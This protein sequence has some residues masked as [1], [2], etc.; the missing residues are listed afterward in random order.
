MSAYTEALRIQQAKAD[1]ADAI[2]GKGVTVP[3]NA[4]ID[5]YPALVDAI[6][7]GSTPTLQ[8]K[9][10]T[11]TTNAQTVTPDAGYD[12]LSQV[13]VGAVTAAIDSNIVGSNIKKD[14]A[15]LGVTGTYE[16]GGVEPALSND[17]DFIDYDG[18]IR[19]SYT[20]AEFLALSAMPA[21]PTHAGLTAQGWNW[22][23][24]DA[25]SYVQSYGKLTIGQMYIT[26]D[27]KTR[28]YIH[29]E[30]GRTSPMVGLLV[31]GTVEV[32][33]GDGTT[34][35][36]VTGN[37]FMYIVWTP[38]H[39]YASPGNYVI[40]IEVVSGAAAFGSSYGAAIL[41]HT[42]TASGGDSAYGN[43]VERIEIGENMTI[44][45]SSLSGLSSLRSITI[46][47]G[48]TTFGNTAFQSIY[49]LSGIVLPSTL[50][51][52]IDRQ[53]NNCYALSRIS[54]PHDVVGTWWQSFGGC[55]TL[56]RAELPEGSTTL[57]ATAFSNCMSLRS[58]VIPEGITS[59]G[60]SGFAN[61]KRLASISV[62]STMTTI[63]SSA[64]NSCSGVKEFHF[65]STT[66]PSIFNSAVFGGIP[67][68]CIFYVPTGSLEAYQ[69][70]TNWSTFADR[71]VEE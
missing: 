10:V 47:N 57:D 11:P 64:F 31:N 41:R 18:T 14:V 28:V 33:W 62:P 6:E 63:G 42:A 60:T 35:N 71:M 21:N 51:G 67:S 70:A 55:S 46:P 9:S 4:L 40:T 1:L 24:A 56:V 30:E 25:K 7:Q 12:G 69:T 50:T 23:L 49:S 58:V 20:A 53:F 45:G 26:D 43:A 52:G 59:I 68:D 29:L 37:N 61:C 65:K 32:D 48:I 3:A 22:S 2:E 19:Y 8:T 38:I 44:A 5:D 39:N 15:I 16:G 54:I 27:G 66:P 17:V 13:S 36:T 34:P